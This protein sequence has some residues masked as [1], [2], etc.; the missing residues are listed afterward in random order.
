MRGGTA[1]ILGTPCYSC[2]RELVSLR[3]DRL[4][5]IGTYDNGKGSEHLQTLFR[6]SSPEVICVSIDEFLATIA[7]A[8]AF[9]INPP[10][11]MLKDFPNLCLAG[12]VRA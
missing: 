4:E 7:K 8:L 1:T 11:G 2:A 9:S 3:V 6:D 12:T 10:G 5:Y